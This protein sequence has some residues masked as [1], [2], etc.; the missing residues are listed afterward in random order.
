MNIMH[1]IFY[2]IMTINVI[3]VL[4]NIWIKANN[5]V[6]RLGVKMFTKKKSIILVFN[7]YIYIIYFIWYWIQIKKFCLQSSI[8]YINNIWGNFSCKYISSKSSRSP[9]R[10]LGGIPV[11]EVG[12]LSLRSLD[13]TVY[14]NY[15]YYYFRI[16]SND[17]LSPCS[18]NDSE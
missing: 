5:Q 7:I 17:K 1:Y 3:S 2:R 16:G 13:S 11:V 15:Y 14:Y 18:H 12:P 4:Y 9:L 6:Y 8:V 10:T